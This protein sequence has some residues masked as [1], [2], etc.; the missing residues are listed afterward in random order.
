[1]CSQLCRPCAIEDAAL[2]DFSV[3]EY[4]EIR[5]AEVGSGPTAGNETEVHVDERAQAEVCDLAGVGLPRGQRLSS[6]EEAQVRALVESERHCVEEDVESLVLLDHPE[7]EKAEPV[8]LQPEPPACLVP[9]A[10][11]P[12]IGA[13]ATHREVVHAAPSEAEFVD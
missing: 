10:G 6:D 12:R 13:G 11:A 9:R 3:R 4:D 7:E 5:S 1:M 8:R 2:E